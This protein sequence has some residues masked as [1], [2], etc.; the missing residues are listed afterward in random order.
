MSLIVHFIISITVNHFPIRYF[1]VLQI[2]VT[3]PDISRPTFPCY[4]SPVYRYLS[5]KKLANC[6]NSGSGILNFFRSVYPFSGVPTIRFPLPK[7]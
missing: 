1:P 4:I 5:E 6:I 7:M 2:P 3:H